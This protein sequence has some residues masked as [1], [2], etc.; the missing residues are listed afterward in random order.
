MHGQ[1][2]LNHKAAERSS[3][4]GCLLALPRRWFRRIVQIA[5]GVWEG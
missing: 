5:F 3:L 1:R 4:D 2:L